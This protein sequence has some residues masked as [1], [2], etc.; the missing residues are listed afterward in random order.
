MATE[1][2]HMDSN[3]ISVSVESAIFGEHEYQ[4]K[5][6]ESVAIV[7][8]KAKRWPG[9]MTLLIGIVLIVIGFV[10]E[11]TVGMM[12]GA[13]A[14]LS[15]SINISRKRSRFGLR[16]MTKRG[17]VFVLASQD[18]GYVETVSIALQTAIDSS[19]N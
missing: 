12:L 6:I 1:I 16:I 2:F 13:V 4:V 8:D 14:L 10:I 3:G 7:E 19:R 11:Q 15:G 17:A 5:N 18:R 9:R